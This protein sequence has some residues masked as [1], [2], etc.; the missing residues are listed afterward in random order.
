MDHVRAFG[1][2][3]LLA[4]IL[5][6]LVISGDETRLSLGAPSSAGSAATFHAAS[7]TSSG[8]SK[9]D[10]RVTE[11]LREH[12][13][14]SVIVTL[15]LPESLSA[16]FSPSEVAELSS[17]IAASQDRVIAAVPPSQ[18]AATRR[19]TV[20]AAMSGYA[21]SAG[22]EALARHP[23]VGH[24]ALNGRTQ[25]ALGE[26][27]PLI[28]A[29]D[30][31]TT[32]GVTGA[33]VVVAV[34]D[35][36]IDTDHP[37]LSDDLIHQECFLTAG[38]CPGG[39][40]TGPSAEDGA[41]HG[42][43]VSG[44]VT[45]SG[46]PIGVAPDAEIE[47]FK[48]LDDTGFGSFDD[49]LAA[50][51]AIIAGH[52][53][54]DVINMSLGDF[55]SHV[56]G[57]CD[58]FIP[59][60]TT[61]IDTTRAMGMTTFV[62]AGNNGSK[63]GIGFPAC[64]TN[65]VSVG[66]VYDADVGA[67]FWSSCSD[68]AT[69]ADQVTCFSQS[70]LL[71]DLLAPGSVIES[72]A[73][74]GG[75][76]T[77]SGTSMAT[78]AAAAVAALLLESEPGLSPA[79]V[80]AR[81][82]ETGTPVTDAANGVIT[83]RVD[84]YEAVIDDGGP[85]CAS[86]TAP[87]TCAGGAN[88]GFEWGAVDS[89][90]IPCWTVVDQPGGSGSWC[91]QTGAA[92]PQGDCAGDSTGVDPPPHGAQAAMTNQAGAGS[93]VLYRCATPATAELGFRLYVNS[94]TAFETPASLDYGVVPNQQ[95]RADL[96][97]AAGMSSDP[98]TLSPGDLLLNL[99]QTQPSDPP[100]S[101]YMKIAGDL[102]PYLGQPVC[103]RIAQVNNQ[104][105]LH[106]GVDAVV[107]G[108]AAC[109]SPP[110]DFASANCFGLQSLWHHEK[111]A[112]VTGMGG[113]TLAFNQACTG[114]DTAGCSYNTGVGVGG[115]AASPAFPPLTGGTLSF[116]TARSTENA[117]GSWDRTFVQYSTDGGFT[118]A[119]LNL[120][121][122]AITPGGQY[123]AAGGE[124]C[125]ESLTAQ[126]VTV[127]LPSGTTNVAFVFESGDAFLNDYAGQFIDDVT[128]SCA[129]DTDGE[130]L[131]DCE[132]LG[133]GTNPLLPDTDS[134]GCSDYRETRTTPGS[135]LVGGL[136]N[137]LSQWDYFNPTGDLENRVDDIVA[138]LDQYFQDDAD[139]TPGFPPF[140]P[141]YTQA[142][143]RT[144]TGPDPWRTGP[145]NGQQRVDDIINA[146]NSY[147]HDCA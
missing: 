48:V 81:L 126:T 87:P 119:F 86:G 73:M 82:R 5:A 46:P 105:F 49:I 57:T 38:T 56:P 137:P 118:Y 108:A 100:V 115:R 136:R 13:V 22:V 30:A 9:I 106:A 88:D 6:V 7:S 20:V 4:A 75:T 8:G 144:L 84:A 142:T 85:V 117:C 133:Y 45:S 102:T 132:E 116:K 141:G 64:L 63:S 143:D 78:P 27:V 23:D 43:H 104:G 21:T 121:A 139:G 122:G 58:G 3:T 36:G 140:S 96:V 135:Q 95:V 77:N 14:V 24:V 103:L 15:G 42:T 17:R 94:A 76:V 67:R 72:A 31:Q 41:G 12:G 65:V 80:E 18:F 101:G 60:L 111:T 47:A 147:F 74:G 39:G 11:A 34:L 92:P 99:Y 127:P 109:H 55:A 107:F 79:D 66:A 35:T 33:G 40:T 90:A 61:A 125:G 69:A 52:P 131:T 91:N 70:H 54:V 25:A 98:F 62:A 59:A 129:A 16:R 114:P 51:N 32:L 134:D 146:I 110:W 68:P 93:R 97:T 29:D 120:L 10:R 50:Y 145:P 124:I 113:G 138:V 128:V 44:I 37:M 112:A 2:L 123:L 83:C 89:N 19:H 28:N 26:A 1:Y 130:G 71:L 53:E